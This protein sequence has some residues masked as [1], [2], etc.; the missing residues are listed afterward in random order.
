MGSF[1]V[2]READRGMQNDPG[3]RE[4]LRAASLQMAWAEKNCAE[5]SV[6]DE[7][8]RE[9][10]IIQWIESTGQWFREQVLDHE[11]EPGKVSRKDYFLDLYDTDPDKAVTELDALFKT[12]RH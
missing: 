8:G 12:S 3:S 2:Y 1:E 6:A 11:T 5:A 10:V 7:D 4:L 9:G